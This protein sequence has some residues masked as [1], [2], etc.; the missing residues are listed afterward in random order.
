[1]GQTNLVLADVPRPIAVG[2]GFFLGGWIPNHQPSWV[3]L[4]LVALQLRPV[5]TISLHVG[6]RKIIAGRLALKVAIL[7]GSRDLQAAISS[8]ASHQQRDTLTVRQPDPRS[9]N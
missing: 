9:N 7:Y 1:V 8:G 3:K 6:W 5:A 4:G 2:S